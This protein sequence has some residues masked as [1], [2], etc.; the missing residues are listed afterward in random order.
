METNKTN[1]LSMLLPDGEG[2]KEMGLT[3]SK[4][5]EKIGWTQRD[6]MDYLKFKTTASID[7]LEYKGGLFRLSLHRF[8]LIQHKLGKG[9]NH[10]LNILSNIGELK[11]T[12]V[13][14]L[15]KA[16]AFLSDDAKEMILSHVEKLAT[17]A[18]EIEIEDRQK[19]IQE[20]GAW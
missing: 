9:L 1:L 13:N 4:M 10:H 20:K 17:P 19:L 18:I 2:W 3:L 7:T 12:D 15:L 8:L 16:W 6:L 5:R 11:T 14:R